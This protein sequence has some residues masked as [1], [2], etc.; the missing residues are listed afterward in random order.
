[1]LA[2]FAQQEDSESPE[3]KCVD[4][5]KLGLRGSLDKDSSGRPGNDEIKA[6]IKETS[7]GPSNQSVPKELTEGKGLKKFVG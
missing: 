6:N 2:E 4:S 5:K 1:M 3:R 7:S